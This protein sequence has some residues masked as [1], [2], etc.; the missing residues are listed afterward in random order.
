MYTTASAQN[1][2]TSM[3]SLGAKR[4]PLED[5]M[6]NR[7]ANKPIDTILSEAHEEGVMP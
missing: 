3:A 1:C 4:S 6:A 7:F 2:G 5:N